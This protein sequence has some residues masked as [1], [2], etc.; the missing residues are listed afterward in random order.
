MAQDNMQMQRWELKYLI[1]EDVALALR[2]F[3]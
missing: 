3:V 2:E 1:P